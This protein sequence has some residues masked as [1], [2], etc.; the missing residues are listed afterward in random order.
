[1]EWPLLAPLPAD[2]RAAVLSAAR[3]RSYGRGE[4]V[5]H[6]GDPADAVHLVT[7][8]HLV[9]QVTTPEGS[10]TTLTVLGPGSHVGE[11]ALTRATGSQPRSATVLALEGAETLSLPAAAFHELC[12]RH[13]AVTQILVE[14]LAARVRELSERLTES[15]SVGLDRRVHRCLLRLADLFGTAPG[16]VVVPMT[17]DQIADLVGGTRPSVNQ[18]L[19]R[20]QSQGVIRLGRGR[21]ELL[22]R[23]VLTRKAGW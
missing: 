10:R 23:A 2:A 21:V 16:A 15:T 5:F 11:L 3:R 19:Q 7:R 22:D 14:L 8:G 12:D 6:E 17:Q 1:M 9:V 13:P 20:L 18:V 4:V